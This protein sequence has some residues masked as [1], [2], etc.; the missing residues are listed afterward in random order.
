MFY[1][2]I[3]SWLANFLE[4]QLVISLMSL[5]I[6]INWGLAVSYMLPL[7]NLIFS[8]LLALFLWGSCIFALCKLTHLP[9]AWITTILDYIT[10]IWYYLLSFA[11]PTW[12]IGFTHNTIWLAS[13][14]ALF[15]FILYTYIKPNRLLALSLLLG[16]GGIILA[17]RYSSKNNKYYKIPHL[18]LALLRVNNKTYL[19]DYGELSSK[20]NFYSHIDYTI[21]P[22]LIKTAGVTTIDTLVLYKPSNR[23]LSTAE[24]IAKQTQINSIFV[25]TKYD[26]YNKLK[27]KL[28]NYKIYPL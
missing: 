3:I 10:H 17:T 4:L 22:A 25:T 12:L 20:Q 27:N 2:K 19:L 11:Q 16:C 15:I 6:I 24:Q 28:S 18:K 5:P 7:A 14:I 9:T 21:L 13:F 26:C 8:P 23:I 1:K